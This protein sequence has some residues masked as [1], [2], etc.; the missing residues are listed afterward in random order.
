[1]ALR[2]IAVAGVVVIVDSTTVIPP[3]TVV[4]TIVVNPPTGLKVRAEAKL[5]HRDGDQIVVSAI[6]VPGAGATI[7][8]PG[9][10]T[11]AMNATAL[12]TKAEGL[13][14][15]REGDQSDVINATPQI[16]GSPSPAPY[17]VSFK[18]VVQTAGQTKVKAQ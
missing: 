1:M 3:G 14:V 12:K 17:P 6:T 11:V 13:E 2:L 10:Y 9:P 4:A 5:V 8:D 15:L 7:P 16:P 18:C